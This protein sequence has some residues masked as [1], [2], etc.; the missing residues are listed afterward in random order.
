MKIAL[1]LVLL[2]ISAAS[3]HAADAPVTQTTLPNGMRV[4]VRENASAGVVA[5]TLLV[6]AGSRFEAPEEAGITHFL[7]RVM[8]RG[9][10]RRSAIDLAAAAEDIGGSI[11]A[12]GDVEYAEIRGTSLARHWETLLGLIADV[13]LHP[14]LLAESIQT[15]RRLILSQLQTRVDAPFQLAF[16][17]LLADMYG[18]HPYALPSVGT[19]PAIE[20]VTREALLKRYQ[21]VYRPERMVLSVS[22]KVPA[23]DVAAAARK[24]FDGFTGIGPKSAG[25]FIEP[26]PSISPRGGRQLME[27][28]AQQAQILMGFAGPAVTDKDYAAVKVL[29]AVLGGGMSGR[30]FVELRDKLGLAYSLG[31][32]N[33]TRAG[34][35]WI[36]GYMGTTPA[37]AEAAEAGMLREIERIRSE[38]PTADEVTRAKAYVAG[39]MAMDRRTNGREAWY[40]GFFELI[41]AG[42][43]FPDRYAQS[44]PQVTPQDVQAAARRYLEHPTI[45]VLRPR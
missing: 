30:L 19:R 25:P 21:A 42:H 6:R 7:H 38:A 35:A 37:S 5:A 15:E 27:R 20:R 45:V 24:L 13:A 44:I 39:T 29:A 9:T 36:L 34:P 28:P 23:R 1:A 2:L 31:V 14:S 10:A 32:Q 11:D 3:A 4:I 33:P 8:I 16:D 40:R 22:G 17:T 41:G 26:A 12:A 18:R 43:E